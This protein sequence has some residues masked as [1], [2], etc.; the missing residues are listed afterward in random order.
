MWPLQASIE[1]FT[2]SSRLT[3]RHLMI[4][5][6]DIQ[7]VFL[8]PIGSDERAFY[9]QRELITPKHIAWQ[10][11]ESLRQ[12]AKRY[13]AHLIDSHEVDRE[14]P[15]VWAG[16]SLGGALA[17]EFSVVHPPHAQILLATFKSDRDLAPIVRAVGR[18]AHDIPIIA[19]K[20]AGEI[21][22]LLMKAMGYMSSND[23][24]M[25]VSGYRRMS[26]R[27]FRNAFKALSEWTGVESPS[28]FPTLRIH[29]KHDP[30]IPIDRTTGVDVVLDTMHLVT[31][32]KPS[33]VN[34]SVTRFLSRLASEA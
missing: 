30:L 11:D 24:D 6:S 14:N 4:Q 15:I 5:I 28:S 34:E 27:S 9:P 25:M 3:A 32:A 26:K 18:I 33:E 7:L 22:P 1:A 17:Q 12:H 21:A 10:D 2:C 29:G 16:L 13:Y 19:Y 31:L 23:I 20:L 8:P